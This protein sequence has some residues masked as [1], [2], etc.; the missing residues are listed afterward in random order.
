MERDTT[1]ATSDAT[2]CR[3]TNLPIS[4]CLPYKLKSN[5]DHNNEL[6]NF[7]KLYSIDVENSLNSSASI[8]QPNFERKLNFDVI[9]S[10]NPTINGMLLL[11]IATRRVSNDVANFDDLINYV[12]PVTDPEEANYDT[13]DIESFP[14]PTVFDFISEINRPPDPFAMNELIP[15]DG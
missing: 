6:Y 2:R 8:F 1:I 9:K 14:F 12:P 11:S 10:E 13:N 3:V 4:S 5:N 7:L 15:G